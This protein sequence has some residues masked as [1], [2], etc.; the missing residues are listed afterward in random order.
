MSELEETTAIHIRAFRQERPSVPMPIREYR[1]DPLRR[2]RFDF[3]WPAQL[4]AIEVEGGTWRRGRHNRAV[5]FEKDCEKYNAA[6][7]AGW[8]VLRY[9]GKMI[10]GGE[11]Y[12]DLE[13]MFNGHAAEIVK[14]V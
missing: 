4:M 3:A 1:F 8:R 5:G 11:L 12:E 13:K 9:T 2:W 7:M 10:N 14:A 6:A